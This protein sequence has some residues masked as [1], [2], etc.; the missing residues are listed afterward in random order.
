MTWCPTPATNSESNDPSDTGD[1]QPPVAPDYESQK[2]IEKIAY[3]PRTDTLLGSQG[4]FGTFGEDPPT[5]MK[6]IRSK[7]CGKT[8]QQVCDFGDFI[9]GQY[10]PQDGNFPEEDW[11]TTTIYE[12][13]YLPINLQPGVDPG[14]WIMM[15]FLGGYYISTDDGVTW[16]PRAYALLEDGVQHAG[17]GGFAIKFG[18]IVGGPGSFDTR[19]VSLIKY[20]GGSTYGFIWTLINEDGVTEISEFLGVKRGLPSGSGIEWSD[21]LPVGYLED[22]GTNWGV[23]GMWPVVG[24]ANGRWIAIVDYWC[25]VGWWGPDYVDREVPQA[26]IN[27]SANLDPEEWG[28]PF[29]LISREWLEDKYEGMADHLISFD[30]RADFEQGHGR[31]KFIPMEGHPVGGRWWLLGIIDTILYS[32]DN[33]ET[34]SKSLADHTGDEEDMHPILNWRHS[35]ELG[36]RASECRVLD[37]A[38]DPFGS[39][40]LISIGITYGREGITNRLAVFSCSTDGGDTW[41]PVGQ[42]P[43]RLDRSGGDYVGDQPGRDSPSVARHIFPCLPIG[44]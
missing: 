14:D 37:I 5:T 6:I 15:D 43:L 39:G 19:A 35:H 33:G 36:Y 11:E 4:G 9:G 18:G 13:M 3:D 26:R 21:S 2:N 32:D 41:G 23:G 17:G 44:E 24:G 16:S 27:Y 28:E 22:G 40:R 7:D 34:W 20:Q 29:C 1:F 10:W 8:W 31:L 30:R 42:L 12:T 38:H 25:S